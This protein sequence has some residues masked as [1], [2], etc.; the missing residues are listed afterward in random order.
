MKSAWDVDPDL[1]L[2]RCDPELL[3]FRTTADLDETA[4][5]IGQDRVVEALRFAI[6]MP[7]DGYNLYVMGPPGIGKQHLVRSR[8]EEAAADRPRPS[9]WC[10]VHNFDHPHKPCAIEL[11]AGG[12]A[13]LRTDMQRLVEELGVQ[14][15]AAFETESYQNRVG[16]LEEELKELHEQ[17]A[18]ELGHVAEAEGVKLMRTPAGFAFAPV[19]DDEV[20]TPENFAKLSEDA[21]REIHEKIKQLQERLQDFMRETVQWGKDS[22][23]KLKELNRG[24]A[25]SAVGYAIAELE[26]KYADRPRISAYLDRVEAD[27]LE[28]VDSFRRATEPEPSPVGL[29]LPGQEPPLERY[30]VNV[31]VDHAQ[32]DGAPVVTEEHPSL[33]NLVGRVEQR[34][35]LGALTTDF[36]LIKPGALHL[37]NGGYLVLDARKLLMQPYSWEALKSAIDNREIRIESLGQYLAIATV[38]L[39][40]EHI[41]L[42]V[43]VVLLGD[44]LLYYML[45]QADPEFGELFKVNADF[46][47]T[48]DRDPDGAQLYA[49]VIASIVRRNE[50]RP[51]DRGGVAR[52]IEHSARRAADAE[53]LST[54]VGALA[55][56]L[57]ESDYWAGQ[58]ERDIVTADDVQQALDARMRRADRM[59]SL[60]QER[61]R[62]GTVLI[63][64]D[65]ESVG[66]INGL[67]VLSMGDS[68]FGQPSRITATARVG[69]GQ[70]VDI[71]REVKLGGPTHSKGVLILSSFLAAR[72]A[73]NRPLSLTASLVFEQSYGRVDGDSASVAETCALLSVLSSVPIKQ[74][75]AVTGSMN[76]RGQVQAIGGVNE[77][78]EGFYDLCSARGLTGEHGVVIPAANVKHLMLRHDVVEAVRAGRFK[79][80]AVETVDEAVEALTGVAAGAADAD[81]AYPDGTV[82]RLVA[83]RLAELYSIRRSV[84]RRPRSGGKG[85]A[86]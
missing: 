69:R 40:P 64:T 17:G 81:G 76:Q 39:E 73:G 83:D 59:R 20:V 80:L 61:I 1:L 48:L 62:R 85:E 23:A 32:T 24:V 9:D 86:D 82:N 63:D 33:P 30:A 36:T 41:P 28:N 84:S 47:D 8:L 22:R 37:A 66:Q 5:T 46:D 50:L 52:V 27:V 74:A 13:E 19:V 55:D 11:P 43:K 25:L 4:D 29:T 6:G 56:L 18:E 51:L 60:V 70:V 26:K 78:V 44:R 7:S 65:G 53:K 68:S 67:S 71:E 16:E 21:Q 10:Y 75:M 34:A 38:T 49:R 57:R 31:L 3:D 54:H 45:H 15:P 12:A 58:T 35:Q 14:I 79:V 42:D 77:K 2:T 72:Y